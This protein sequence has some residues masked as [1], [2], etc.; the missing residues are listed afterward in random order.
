MSKEKII[1][2]RLLNK[3]DEF[4][5]MEFATKFNNSEEFDKNWKDLKECFLE[6]IEKGGYKNDRKKSIRT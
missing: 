2:L 6:F 5:I 3:D 1:S 4:Q